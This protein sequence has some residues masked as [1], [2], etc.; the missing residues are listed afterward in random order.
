MALLFVNTLESTNINQSAP[1]LVKHINDNKILD[2]L[3]YGSN[4]TRKTGVVCPCIKKKAIFHFVYA[5]ASTIF[6]QS[7]LNLAKIYIT[8]RS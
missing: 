1:N 2:E 6:N 8:I 4:Q 3:D 7:A 5:L